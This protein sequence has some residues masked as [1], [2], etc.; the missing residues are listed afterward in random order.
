VFTA[1]YALSPYIKQIRFVFKGLNCILPTAGTVAIMELPLS[2][3]TVGLHG[4]RRFVDDIL[5]QPSAVTRQTIRN[6]RR[7][8]KACL[9]L[10]SCCK[11][12][13]IYVAVQ[14]IVYVQNRFISPKESGVTVQEG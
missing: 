12:A 1:R 5:Q 6:Y 4:F 13:K 11:R 8:L 9:H 2:S 7:N 10:N 3:C 14:S